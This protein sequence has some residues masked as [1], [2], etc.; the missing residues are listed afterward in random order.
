MNTMNWSH[1]QTKC[2]ER[3]IEWTI[4]NKSPIYGRKSMSRKISDAYQCQ[5]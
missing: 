2:G 4:I 3:D 1:H 5:R